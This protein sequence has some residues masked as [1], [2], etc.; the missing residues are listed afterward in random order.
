MAVPVVK[1]PPSIA[2]QSAVE[3]PPELA[4][5]MPLNRNR[6]SAKKP[7]KTDTAAPNQGASRLKASS[8]ADSLPTDQQPEEHDD[9]FT[10]PSLEGTAGRV[11]EQPPPVT[12]SCHSQLDPLDGPV[13]GVAKNGGAAPDA[14]TAPIATASD[15]PPTS[16]PSQRI[17]HCIVEGDTL[18]DLAARYLGDRSRYGEI[19]QANRQILPDPRLLPIGE[20]IWIECPQPPKKRPAGAGKSEG[21]QPNRGK[22]HAELARPSQTLLAGRD[23]IPVPPFSS[24]GLR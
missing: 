6:A 14:A 22:K 5:S 21:K 17:G 24:L 18:P 11:T 7:A 23:R 1:G 4:A 10:S 9:P 20:E 2:R 19:F 16:T 12:E 13:A 3:A 15:G 8:H